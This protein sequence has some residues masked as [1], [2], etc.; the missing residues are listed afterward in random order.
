LAP[1]L[2]LPAWG[3]GPKQK[4]EKKVPQVGRKGAC[5]S[6]SGWPQTRKWVGEFMDARSIQTLLKAYLRIV[7]KCPCII[8]FWM[9][10]CKKKLYI[11]HG[12]LVGVGSW[13]AKG[14]ETSSLQ[15]KTCYNPAQKPPVV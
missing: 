6:S 7:I 8:L 10:I 15:A 1:P 9:K 4:G 14:F 11:F 5:N 2:G 3:Q 12:A 13:K